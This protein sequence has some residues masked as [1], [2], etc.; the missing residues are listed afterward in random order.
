MVDFIL[1]DI[2]HIIQLS[3]APVFLLAGV[4]TKLMVLT[5]RF[6]RIIDRSRDLEERISAQGAASAADLEEL[7]ALDARAH[8]I[9]RAVAL[10]TSCGLLVCVVVATLFVGN[11]L[12]F[13]FE[14]FIAVAF[15]LAMVSLIGSFVFLLWEISVATKM[16]AA[17]TRDRAVR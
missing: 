7:N 4:G 3:V 6:A 14:T 8:L 17:R 16:L 15:T 12:G 5:N 1:G 9:N 11:A 10:A 2:G 13:R